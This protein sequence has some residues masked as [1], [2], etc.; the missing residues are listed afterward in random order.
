[1]NRPSEVPVWA[2]VPAA[3]SGS[4]M[5][6]DKPKQYLRFQG[7]TIIEHCLDRLLSHPHI[8]GAVLVLSESDRFWETLS[9]RF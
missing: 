8:D 7:K 1:M 9:L 6:S 3:G 4:R 2:V 5:Q